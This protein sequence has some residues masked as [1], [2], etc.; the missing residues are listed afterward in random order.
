MAKKQG[1]RREPSR[2]ALAARGVKTKS[3]DP[4]KLKRYERLH[5]S[6]FFDQLLPREKQ[7]QVMIN[8]L[9]CFKRVD[10]PAG[11]EDSDN[12]GTTGIYWE[13]EQIT[14]K[15]LRKLKK[16]L[17]DSM[18]FWIDEPPYEIVSEK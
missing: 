17:P 10:L 2:H 6:R 4:R 16:E 7:I 8:A 9:E 5:E 3:P 12:S 15:E 13:M 14:D 1:W 18:P 11:Y